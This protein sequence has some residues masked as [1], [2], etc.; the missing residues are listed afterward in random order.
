MKGITEPFNNK[1]AEFGRMTPVASVR[2][3]VFHWGTG[4]VSSLHAPTVSSADFLILVILKI[5]LILVL[6]KKPEPEL[7][8][9]AML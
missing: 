4:A 5:L 1:Q 8:I 9:L 7:P 3:G 6:T 2:T